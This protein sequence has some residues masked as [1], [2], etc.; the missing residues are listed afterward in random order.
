[1]CYGDVYIMGILELTGKTHQL[2]VMMIG[3]SLQKQLQ[4]KE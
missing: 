1:M 4:L 3:I 2:N